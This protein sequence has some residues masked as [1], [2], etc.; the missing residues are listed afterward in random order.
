MLNIIQIFKLANSIRKPFYT[1]DIR[2]KLEILPKEINSNLG[3]INKNILYLNIEYEEKL[4]I[5][6]NKAI[7]LIDEILPSKTITDNIIKL[8]SPDRILSFEPGKKS[9]HIEIFSI[10]NNDGCFGIQLNYT[11]NSFLIG[12]PERKNHTIANLCSTSPFRYRINGKSD[13]TMTGRKQRTFTEFDYSFELFH[14][15]RIAYIKTSKNGITKKTP[16]NIK[17]ID[18][19]KLLI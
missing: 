4:E 5:S 16:V 7:I 2:N 18:E 14:V 10:V 13:F 11:S 1:T 12:K 19:R 17:I 6:Q 9:K 3:F 8:N 15:E